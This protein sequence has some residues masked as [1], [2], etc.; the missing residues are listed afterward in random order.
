MVVTLEGIKHI[1]HSEWTDCINDDFPKSRAMLHVSK[2]VGG[3]SSENIMYFLNRIVHEY[4]ETYLEIGVF[5]GLTLI[6]AAIWNQARCIGVENFSQGCRKEKLDENLAKFGCT[7]IEML[8][9]DCADL[10]SVFFSR[11]PSP[12]VN[13]FFYDGSKEHIDHVHQAINL[14]FPHLSNNCIIII[15]DA[16]HPV[17]QAFIPIFK[18]NHPDFQSISIPSHKAYSS[19]HEGLEILIREEPCH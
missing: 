7:N 13:I 17:N 8:N 5:H 18:Q 4:G 6:S 16:S 10:D 2:H 14:V 15:D 1:L 3:M 9:I 11:N 19:W 12:K